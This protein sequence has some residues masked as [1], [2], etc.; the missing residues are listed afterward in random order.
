MN[1]PDNKKKRGPKQKG[2][3]QRGL[4]TPILNS[5]FGYAGK[6]VVYGLTTED[7]PNIIH[8]VGQTKTELNR[9]YGNHLSDANANGTPKE[10]WVWDLTSNDQTLVLVVLEEGIQTHD[11]ACER[12]QFYI[13]KLREEQHPLKN[14]TRGGMGTPGRI[15]SL[16][17]RLKSSASHINRRKRATE[18]NIKE[19]K[20][21]TVTIGNGKLL[22]YGTSE[23]TLRYNEVQKMAA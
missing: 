18:V 9:R 5:Y 22:D 23:E 12:E 20:E 4:H 7:E 11:D 3:Y 19:G 21:K 2:R 6:Y 14:A 8:Y 15:V 13:Q 16:E 10:R 17:S 1:T